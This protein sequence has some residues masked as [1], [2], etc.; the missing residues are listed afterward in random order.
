MLRRSAVVGVPLHLD[1]LDLQMPDDRIGDF[2][3]Q[4][5]GLRQDHR[6]VQRELDL[7]LDGDLL[8]RD[9]DG[10]FLGNRPKHQVGR[11]LLA[12]LDVDRHDESQVAIRHDPHLGGTGG[13][14]LELQASRRVR[15]QPQLL[16]LRVGEGNLDAAE[17][18]TGLGVTHAADH[19]PDARKGLERTVDRD[20]APLFGDVHVA[21][22]LLVAIGGDLVG[23]SARGHFVAELAIRARRQRRH[24]GVVL[25]G[26]D[27]SDDRVV[28]VLLV[29]EAD[30]VSLGRQLLDDLLDHLGLDDRRPVPRV[31]RPA[32]AEKERPGRHRRQLLDEVA[33]TP[34]AD[35]ERG[36]QREAPLPRQKAAADRQ[37]RGHDRVVGQAVVLADVVRAALPALA[38]VRD[39][40]AP[41]DERPDAL[42]GQ[43]HLA[44]QEKVHVVDAVDAETEALD[45]RPR[46][47]GV[48]TD[49]LRPNRLGVGEHVRRVVQRVDDVRA[50]PQRDIRLQPA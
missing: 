22:P 40:Q 2:G 31:D 47:R 33:R 13:D 1:A 28:L 16:V 5:E 48:R 38:V 21:R 4:P 46:N 10:G 20:L 24:L 23:P 14:A 42:L 37:R 32:C 44:A 12:R 25:V 17:R 3:E 45:A 27:R 50:E 19:R 18:L 35:V 39:E 43:K 15:R 26:D 6:A 29:D 7:L 9:L 30:H 49:G 34:Q 11:V 41:L 8:G 36:E